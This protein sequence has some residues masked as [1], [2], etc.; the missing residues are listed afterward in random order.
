[1]K[2]IHRDQ[3]CN[4]HYYAAARSRLLILRVS[5]TFYPR[6]TSRSFT[7]SPYSSSPSSSPFATSGPLVAFSR[8]TSSP[9]YTSFILGGSGF[10]FKNW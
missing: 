8:V 4:Y 7:S 5:L 1:M 3:C 9:L 10:P 6:I 2:N